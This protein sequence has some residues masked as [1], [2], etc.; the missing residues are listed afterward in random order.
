MNLFNKVKHTTISHDR[1]VGV[2]FILAT[3]LIKK[4]NI[5]GPR[6]TAI[7]RFDCTTVYEHVPQAHNNYDGSQLKKFSTANIV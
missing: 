7:D 2:Q 3:S 1:Y 6:V 5:F 4:A